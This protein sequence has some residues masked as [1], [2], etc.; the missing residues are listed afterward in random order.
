MPDFALAFVGEQRSNAEEGLER[1]VGRGRPSAGATAPSW[2][3]LYVPVIVG[4]YIQK[5]GGYDNDDTM[6]MA[7]WWITL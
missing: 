6:I 7:L 4:V 1:R 3:V 5:Y 2:N